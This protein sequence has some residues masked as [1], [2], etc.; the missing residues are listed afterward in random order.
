[1][2][3]S[4]EPARAGV[5]PLPGAL[6]VRSDDCQP[7]CGVSFPFGES[8]QLDEQN[9]MSAFPLRLKLTQEFRHD[10]E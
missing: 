2:R 9:E 8:A 6:T 1:M 4:G 7:G 5:V 10:E 3:A